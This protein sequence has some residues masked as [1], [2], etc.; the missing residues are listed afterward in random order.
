MALEGQLSDFSLEEILQLIAVQ[1]KSGF[2]VLKHEREI[3]FYFDRGVLISTRDRRNPGDDPLDAY[4]HRYGFLK[5]EQW[6]HIEFVLQHAKL[7]LTEVLTSENLLDEAALTA[8][9]Q[10]LAQELVHEGM[11]IKRGQ[12]HFT[13]TTEV[14]TGVRGRIAM[15]VQGLLMEGARRLDEEPRLVE[16]LPSLSMTFE[17]GPKPPQAGALGEISQ[18]LLRLAT[19]G[20]SLGEIIAQG[21]TSAF[22]ARELL[23]NLCESGALI[24]SKTELAQVIQLP[25]S[26]QADGGGRDALRQP[27]LVALLCLLLLAGAVAQWRPLL[28]GPAPPDLTAD[29]DRTAI[30]GPQGV[31]CVTA[32]QIR[33]AQLRDG[34]EQA[35]LLYHRQHGRHPR[36]LTALVEE[37]F[38]DAGVP[39]TLEARGWRYQA[40]GGHGGRLLAP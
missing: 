19:Q 32:E 13:A 1:Q 40:T 31:A 11:K 33:L 15:D 18:R 28:A 30:D 4:L 2:L 16:K 29:A 21:R 27:A 14:G 12:Y 6:Q 3:V 17:P 10:G 36:A 9:L 39:T 26:R 7:D 37:G 22:M 24:A 35:I 8:V 25:V 34:V 38:L 5:P 20:L 23:A